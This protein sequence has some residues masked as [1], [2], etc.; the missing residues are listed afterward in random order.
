[1]KKQE[2][3]KWIK[4]FPEKLR[5]DMVWKPFNLN[6]MSLNIIYF[7]VSNNTREG[8]KILEEMKIQ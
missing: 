3:L 7:E 4:Q 2:L 6:P 8:K 5:K 1:M